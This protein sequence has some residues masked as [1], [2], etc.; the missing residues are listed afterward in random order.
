M[1]T[2]GLSPRIV[3]DIYVRWLELHRLEESKRTSHWGNT[4]LHW[5]QAL[6]SRG[7]SESE[8]LE[9]MAQWKLKYGPF[10]SK[11][12]RF[13]PS[14]K[15]ISKAFEDVPRNVSEVN[16]LKPHSVDRASPQSAQ[17]VTHRNAYQVSPRKGFVSYDYPPHPSYVC[18][19]C[20]EPGR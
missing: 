16:K 6:R 9:N 5:T 11:S 7:F 8:L 14:S 17:Q 20:G 3:L 12:R 18:N 2:K 15:E 10:R 19:R 1:R 13:P 4:I